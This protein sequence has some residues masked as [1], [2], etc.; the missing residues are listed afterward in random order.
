MTGKFSLSDGHNWVSNCL[1]DVPPN[2]SHDEEN[3]THVLYF[4]STFVGTYLILELT[5][6]VINIKSD[7]ISVITIIKVNKHNLINL[8]VIFINYCS[9]RIN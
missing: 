1:P 3:K 4:K 9:Y 6:G 5:S 8:F 2:V 7:N